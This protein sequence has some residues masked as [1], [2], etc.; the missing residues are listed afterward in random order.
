MDGKGTNL[1]WIIK[2]FVNIKMT[3]DFLSRSYITPIS[4][5][6]MKRTKLF[7]MYKTWNS[8]AGIS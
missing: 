8:I 1:E 5:V 3:T 6:N 4:T 7:T 2:D